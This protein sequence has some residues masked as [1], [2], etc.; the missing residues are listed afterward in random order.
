MS[1]SLLNSI[2]KVNKKFTF[3]QGFY[4]PKSKIVN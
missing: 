2:R 3:L 4:A 1:L